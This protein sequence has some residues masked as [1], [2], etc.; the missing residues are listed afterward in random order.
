MPRHPSEYFIRYLLTLTK[1]QAQDN[2]WIQYSV[3]SMGFPA[4]EEEYLDDLR[5]E[6]YKDLPIDYDPENRYNRESVKFL[7]KHGIWSMH[8]QDEEV[9]QALKIIPNYRARRI[10]E[11][12][13]L[14]RIEDREVTKKANSRLGEFYTTGAI[15]A[16][17]HYFWNTKLLKTQDWL[18]FFEAYET[19]EASSSIAVL[20]GGPAMALHLTGFRQN[21]ECKEMLKD[22]MEGLYFDFREWQAQPRSVNKT[23]AMT[24]IA[25]AAVGIDVRMSEAD[26]ALRD[27]LKAFEAFRMQHAQ[28]G[29]KSIDEIAPSGNFTESGAEIKELPMP[30]KEEAVTK[31]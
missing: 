31:G 16:Y 1:P 13:L 21:L 5:K 26:S 25:K 20:Q 27:S 30:K 22:M 18:V 15:K 24:N 19:S 7:R 3:Q 2:A 8:N 23:K 28:K 14:G 11:Q 4:P 12:L 10:I 9:K 17:R 29:V 6:L